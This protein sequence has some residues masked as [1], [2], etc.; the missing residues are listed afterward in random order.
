M[1]PPP[2]DIEP[3]TKKV[4]GCAVEVHRALGPGLLA[5]LWKDWYRRSE[6]QKKIEIRR[7]GL[8][9]RKSRHHAQKRDV[10]YR[11]G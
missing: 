9:A 6:D 10:L 11:S 4:I 1:Y 7:S 5:E 2:V 3:L 8:H